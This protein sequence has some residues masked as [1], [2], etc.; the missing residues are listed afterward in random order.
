MPEV[1]ALVAAARSS[2]EVWL[3]TE[4]KTAVQRLR[5]RLDPDDQTLLVLRIDRRLD[6]RDVARVM[7]TGEATLRK[8]YERLKRR[9]REMAREDVA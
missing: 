5:E 4:V 6:W 3:R 7:E 1:A 9:L 8:R 2:T